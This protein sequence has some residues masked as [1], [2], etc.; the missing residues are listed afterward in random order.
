MAV[1]RLIMGTM[2]IIILVSPK[3]VSK[4]INC[5]ILCL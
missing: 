4:A 5:C 1:R 3:R 2:N